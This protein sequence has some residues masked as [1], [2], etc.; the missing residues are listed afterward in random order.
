MEPFLGQLMLCP[1]IF[2]AKGWIACN[3]QLQAIQQNTALFSLIGTSYGGDGI[4]TFGLP[5]LQGVTP[6]GY[7]IDQSS[8]SQYQI[9]QTG[10]VAAYTL[11]PQE[12]PLHTHTV[13]ASKAAAN[14]NVPSG[15]MLAGTGVFTAP[16]N[17]VAMN[18]AVVTPAGGS[19]PHEN[20]QPYL[21]MNWCISMQGIFPSRN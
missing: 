17:L 5:N 12:V 1:W 4:R 18:N 8:G 16:A 10:G 19:Q 6:I 21:V 3:G 11:N 9:G 2:A 14:K 20:R 13:N 15:G 7:G